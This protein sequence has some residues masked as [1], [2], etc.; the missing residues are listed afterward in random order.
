M[1]KN[2]KNDE[3][4]VKAPGW[5]A[6]TAIV[7]GNMVGIGVFTSLVY[8]L[9]DVSSNF[10]ILLLWVLGGIYAI[11]G[12]LCYGELVACRPR[13]GGEYHLLSSVYHPLSLIHI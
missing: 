6:A 1:D 8:Q 9:T 7:V 10:S 11:C 13:C 5:S 3:Q 2:S 4:S 12:A